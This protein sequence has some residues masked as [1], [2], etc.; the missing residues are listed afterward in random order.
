MKIEIRNLFSVAEDKTFWFNADLWINGIP[1]G[2]V[3]KITGGPMVLL[4]KNPLVAGL[5]RKAELYCEKMPPFEAVG[6]K[7]RKV[8]VEMDLRNYILRVVIKQHLQKERSETKQAKIKPQ[9]RK[10]RSR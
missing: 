7:G 5:I 8:M 6:K 9:K 3:T 2:A 1:V 10:G 4:P